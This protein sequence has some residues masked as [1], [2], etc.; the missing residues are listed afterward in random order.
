MLVAIDF[1]NATTMRVRRA[2]LAAACL[3]ITLGPVGCRASAS[4]GAAPPTSPANPRSSRAAAL[5]LDWL[6][7]LL[8]NNKDHLADI[9]GAVV[10]PDS[11]TVRVRPDGKDL[12]ITV[13]RETALPFGEHASGG[14]RGPPLTIVDYDADGSI[15]RVLAWDDVDGDGRAERQL[16]YA[17]TPAPLGGDFMS[18]IVVD[19]RAQ[20]RG[21]FA[22]DHWQYRQDT[23]Q[24]HSDFSG[25][26]FH[27][28]GRYDDKYGRWHSYGEN[29]FC[30]YDPDGDG[31]TEEALL[32]D[33][34]DAYIRHIR[35]SFDADNDASD[36]RP[37]D[38]DL[39]LTATGP[40]RGAAEMCDSLRLLG[41]GQLPIIRWDRAREFVRGSRWQRI[42]LVWDENDR[43]IAPD[44]RATGERWEGVIAEGV[45]GFAMV[46]GPGCGLVDK[47]YELDQD[48]DGRFRLYFSTIDGR[49]H[50]LGAERGW[51]RIDGDSDGRADAVLQMEDRDGDDRFDTWMWGRG[52]EG[53]FESE[54]SAVDTM[55]GTIDPDFAEILA[56]ESRRLARYTPADTDSSVSRQAACYR[57]DVS[58]W[59]AQGGLRPR[60]T[61]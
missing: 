34:E 26:G 20:Q 6:A 41:G 1:R 13:E 22:L 50:L 2:S 4:C 9:E 53:S 11:E 10:G 51:L 29:P 36:K 7:A 27:A 32:L 17:L 55:G 14:S 3:V 43:N 39:S 45:P 61:D 23:C 30:F 58:R 33:G 49:I 8:R 19:Q 54:F 28:L 15:D 21:Y 18:C 5:G 42:L 40:V 31:L 52:A 37:Y 12:V 16:L 35:L 24:Q 57:A 48:G 59:I 38:Y 60:V 25:D 46:G 44:D 47:R 56:A